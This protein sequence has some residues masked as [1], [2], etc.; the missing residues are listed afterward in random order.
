MIDELKR[1]NK[2]IIIDV[3]A[4]ITVGEEEFV[5]L[6]LLLFLTIAFIE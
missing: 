1:V 2:V 4:I 3:L 5:T 6:P